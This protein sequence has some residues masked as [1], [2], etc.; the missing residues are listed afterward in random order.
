MYT[1]LCITVCIWSCP[2]LSCS[3]VFQCAVCNVLQAE[4]QSQF[5][6]LVDQLP[7]SLR[8]QLLSEHLSLSSDD[9]A[10]LRSVLTESDI[11]GPHVTGSS[12]G[13]R[14]GSNSHRED[15]GDGLS[16]QSLDRDGGGNQMHHMSNQSRHVH[17]SKQVAADQMKGG[18][19]TATWSNLG[20]KPASD[21]PARAKAKHT[22][23]QYLATSSFTNTAHTLKENNN[24]YH[25]S[26]PENDWS[27]VSSMVKPPISPNDQLIAAIL[28]G[29][30]QGVRTIVR[31]RGDSLLS[32]YWRDLALS[33]LPLHRAISGLHFHGSDQ[34]LIHTI[35]T[36][37]QLG[38]SIDARDHAGN[39]VLH[40]AIQVCTST[41]VVAVVECIIKKGASPSVRNNVGQCPIHVECSRC[42]TKEDRFDLI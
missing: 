23:A 11:H 5:A 26:Y 34:K 39:T 9:R 12:A 18:S 36:L 13:G 41:S 33:V 28:D 35:E 2:V 40:K 17:H 37:V 20:P 29:D 16:S 32:E 3:D 38:A 10:S 42:N 8:Q 21:L 22:S 27:S 19:N 6:S 25:N 4:M 31:S 7:D 24:A 15:F 30:V 1:T 14:G